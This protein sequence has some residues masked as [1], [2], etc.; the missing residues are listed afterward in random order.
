[1]ITVNGETLPHKA[2]MTIRDILKERGFVFPL[3]VVRVNGVLVPRDHF[4]QE[5][6]PDDADVQV[7]HLMSGG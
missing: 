5:K 4:D 6:V 2:G 7:L 1:M 3:L